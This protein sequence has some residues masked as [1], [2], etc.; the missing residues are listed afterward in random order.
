[1]YEIVATI[2]NMT[3]L[4]V[5]GIIYAA[6]IK[7]LR[8]VNQLKDTQLKVAEQNVKLWKDRVLELERR[9]PEFIE[10]QLSERIKIREEEISRLAK[11]SESHTEQISHKNKEID[12]LKSRIEK[13][14][15]Y[16][17]SITVWD[18]EESD[19]VEVSDTDLDQ[20]HIGSL[21]V[22]TASLMI[23]DPW[24]TK[25]TDEVE[26]DECPSQSSMYRV[27]NTGE[28]F[29]VDDE[30]DNFAPELLGYDDELTIKDMV[31]MGALEKVDYNGNIPAIETS[32]IKG[33]LRD[34]EYKR[35]R[36]L[37]FSNGR[38]GAGIVVSLGADGVYQVYV[39]SYKGDMQRI[40]IN[41]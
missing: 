27:V 2:A 8:S 26:K 16:R 5:V 30:E 7:N 22:D 9:T 35:I 4:A 39:E 6:Y 25:M 19:F 34:P 40:I 17:N 41:V 29:C 32:Y 12:A 14:T 18:R 10:K 23:C 15:Q 20:K 36:H 1:M 13:A 37:T 38:L 28:F 11:D 3:A 31:S 21:C 33:D 24:Y